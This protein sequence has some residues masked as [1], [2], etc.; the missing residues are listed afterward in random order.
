MARRS[1][2]M[3]LAG[4]HG[5]FPSPTYL[6]TL[7]VYQRYTSQTLDGVNPDGVPYNPGGLGSTTLRAVTRC[8]DF[9]ARDTDFPKVWARLNCLSRTPPSPGDIFTTHAGHGRAVRLSAVTLM[10]KTGPWPA[11]LLFPE[12]PKHVAV[13][14]YPYWPMGIAAGISAAHLKGGRSYSPDAT[15]P[16]ILNS[17]A[18]RTTKKTGWPC[19]LRA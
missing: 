15:I 13:L 4:Q 11:A 2:R 18:V 19:P 9:R 10:A 12:D 8:T 17:H 6:G 5:D 7:P 16:V 3:D 14:W 1:G